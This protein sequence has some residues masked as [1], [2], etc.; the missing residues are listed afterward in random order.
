M[1]WVFAAGLLVVVII[2]ASKDDIDMWSI[3]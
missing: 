1:E 3:K 2:A